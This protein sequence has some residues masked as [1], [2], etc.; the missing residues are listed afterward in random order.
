M[1]AANPRDWLTLLGIDPKSAHDLAAQIDRQ[2]QIL[3]KVK[4]PHEAYY[5]SGRIPTSA[6][7][8]LSRLLGPDGRAFD[9]A[10]PLAALKVMER[11]LIAATQ[12]MG[13]RLVFD[14][15]LGVESEERL[16][17][18]WS[19]WFETGEFWPHMLRGQWHV[20][21]KRSAELLLEWGA[22]QGLSKIEGGEEAV[23]HLADRIRML[24][25]AD[26]VPPAFIK[27]F[28]AQDGPPGDNDW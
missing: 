26:V 10:L 8:R 20:I 3:V 17:E 23:K 7:A 24:T 4:H 27:V 2:R 12:D 1:I 19:E 18:R 6:A 5:R 9:P 15:V 11:G 16:V 14:T 28:E 13:S 22:E 21:L 25:P